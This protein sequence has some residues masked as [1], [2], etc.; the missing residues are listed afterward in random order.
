MA[1]Y[2]ESILGVGLAV[3]GFFSSVTALILRYP[4]KNSGSQQN[5]YVRSSTCQAYRDGDTKMHQQVDQ[6]FIELNSRLNDIFERLDNL[7]TH[8]LELHQMGK[9][10]GR[11]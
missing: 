1:D 9:R 3:F 8:I 7:S 5:G 2:P 11:G 6:K 4:S 10:I